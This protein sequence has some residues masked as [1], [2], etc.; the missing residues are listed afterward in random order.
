MLRGDLQ[1]GGI[2]VE[3]E[4]EVVNLIFVAGTIS[5]NTGPKVSRARFYKILAAMFQ[6]VAPLEL[7]H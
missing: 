4:F 3:Q 7:C 2:Y 5:G 6:S 1:G